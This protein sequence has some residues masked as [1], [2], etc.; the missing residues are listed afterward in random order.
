[1][2]DLKIRGFIREVGENA[3]KHGFHDVMKSPLEYLA[4]I[5]SEVSEVVG[6]LR[7][8][9]SP[10][11]TFTREATAKILTAAV[12]RVYEPGCKFD[13]MLVLSGPPGVGKSMSIEKLAGEWFS[14]NLTFS[15]MGDKTAAENIQGY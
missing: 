6:E 15:D 2:T 9:W 7:R 4:M 11:E 10:D 8:G 14:D 12:R 5:H 13:T 3:E 1:M